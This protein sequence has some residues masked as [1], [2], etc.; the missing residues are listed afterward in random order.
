MFEEGLP[1][2]PRPHRC[3]YLQLQRMRVH[4]LLEQ[5]GLGILMQPCFP[6][7][8]LHRQVLCCAMLHARIGPASGTQHES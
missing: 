4:G 3:Q 1:D 8:P 6:A 7:L 2:E 5:A